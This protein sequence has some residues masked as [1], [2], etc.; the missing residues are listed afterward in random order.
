MPWDEIAT[1][2]S[3]TFND[4]PAFILEDEEDA[5]GER[6]SSTMVIDGTSILRVY[7]EVKVAGQLAFMTS[8][9][10]GFM[11]YDESWSA[12]DAKPAESSYDSLQTCVMASSASKC[13]PGAMK[14]EK[15]VHT[16][17]VLDEH[18]QI[19]VGAGK[20]DTVQVERISL[21]DPAVQGDEETKHFWYAAGVGKVRELEVKNGAT[22]ELSAYDIP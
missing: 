2:R 12:S 6:S 16:F 14:V 17:K 4:K 7:K 21:G 5:Q 13:A 22:E 20:F 10:P 11:R 19:E 1:M 8:Y 9:D 18:A 3:A 15:T